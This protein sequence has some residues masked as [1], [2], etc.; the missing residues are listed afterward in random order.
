MTSECF[1]YT[2]LPGKTEAVTAGEFVQPKNRR[3]ISLGKFIYGKS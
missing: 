3:G 2:I 1:I